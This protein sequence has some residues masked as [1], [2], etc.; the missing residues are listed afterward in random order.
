MA[1]PAAIAVAAADETQLEDDFWRKKPAKKKASKNVNGNPTK[2]TK[3]VP[4]IKPSG[5]RGSKTSN[6]EKLAILC[7]LETPK[8]FRLITGSAT[9]GLKIVTAGK[10]R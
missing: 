1:T 7:W 6:V 5:S 4:E 9:A 8:N 10:N 2:R 3:P